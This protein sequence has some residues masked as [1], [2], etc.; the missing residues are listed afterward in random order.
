VTPESPAGAPDPRPIAPWLTLAALLL[1][2]VPGAVRATVTPAPDPGPA[3]T[4]AGSPAAAATKAPSYP[5]RVVSDLGA[6]LSGPSRLDAAGWRRLG[7]GVAAVGLTAAF[8]ESLRDVVQD[9]RSAGSDRFARAVRPLGQLGAVALVGGAWIAGA[10]SDNP[11]LTAVGK[12][13]IEAS[14]LAA[15][16][17]APVLERASGRARPETGEG[18]HSF[19]PFS[20]DV[21]FPSGEVTEAF[22]VASVISAHS[23]QPWVKGIAWGAAGLVGW[24]RM[25]LDRHWASDVVAGALLGTG[26]GEWVVHRQRARG[27]DRV[28]AWTVAP[29]DRGAAVVLTW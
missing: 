11:A 15:G 22:A 14:L 18:P 8:D 3:A 28:L 5:R 21:S 2:A 23:R 24:E 20:G 4:A 16:L 26:I 12:D 6:L 1:V 7:L 29:T 19:H 10:A 13:G 9:H 27:P 17:L 25:N